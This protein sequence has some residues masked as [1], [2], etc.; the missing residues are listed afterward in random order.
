MSRDHSGIFTENGDIFVEETIS[1]SS[2]WEQ[3]NMQMQIKR[4]EDNVAALSNRHRESKLV[5][6]SRQKEEIEIK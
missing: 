1:D 3:E 5:L 4:L 2:K 6:V